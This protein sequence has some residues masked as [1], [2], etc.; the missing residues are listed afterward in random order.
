MWGL[1]EPASVRWSHAGCAE[2]L[3]ERRHAGRPALKGVACNGGVQRNLEGAALLLYVQQRVLAPLIARNEGHRVLVAIANLVRRGLDSI[4]L[5]RL[6]HVVEGSVALRL[7]V[8]DEERLASLATNDGV[9]KVR[10]DVLLELLP[11]RRHRR[12]TL[13]VASLAV[14]IHR[15][16]VIVLV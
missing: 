10:R 8:E 12:L 14:L 7:A 15:K 16:R 13:P 9:H 5:T 1:W 2:H 3:E 6:R 11:V 4:F